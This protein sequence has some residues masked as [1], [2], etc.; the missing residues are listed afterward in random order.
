MKSYLL[1]YL[2]VLLFLFLSSE[3]CTLFAQGGTNLSVKMSAWRSAVV[4]SSSAGNSLYGI[5]GEFISGKSEDS[6]NQ[7]VFGL[8]NG[9]GLFTDVDETDGVLP[10]KM[11]LY[12][13]YPNPFNPV[14]NIKYTLDK[15]GNVKLAIYDLLGSE[16]AVL[17]NDFNQP[18]SYSVSFNAA[19][20][21]SGIYIYRLTADNFIS[22]KKFVLLK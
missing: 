10:L 11:D 20:L 4:N 12:Q 7:V 18:G 15:P 16:V 8:V 14:T 19:D 5:M 2:V 6:R 21:A 17:V 9:I 3:S 13:N 1:K 22:T